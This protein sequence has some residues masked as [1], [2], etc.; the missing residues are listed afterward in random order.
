MLRQKDRVRMG[1]LCD[2][3]STPDPPSLW[4]DERSSLGRRPRSL[5]QIGDVTSTV[6]LPGQSAALPTATSAAVPTSVVADQRAAVFSFVTLSFTRHGS[7]DSRHGILMLLR[8]P[9][10]GWPSRLLAISRILLSIFPPWEDEEGNSS[11]VGCKSLC[12]TIVQDCV[13]AKMHWQQERPGPFFVE[14]PS[15]YLLPKDLF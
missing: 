13:V 1:S 7:A 11:I 3:R 14:P 5:R 12:G 2:C 4:W 10:G 15:L 8:C 9:G 6:K